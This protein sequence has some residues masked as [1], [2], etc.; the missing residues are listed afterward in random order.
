MEFVFTITVLIIAYQLTVNTSNKRQIKGLRDQV[1]K[2]TEQ[3]SE[4]N[5][6]YEMILLYGK[7]VKKIKKESKE[8]HNEKR[9]GQGS[10]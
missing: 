7:A 4:S 3:V 9:S 8:G 10:D 5:Q 2:L 1:N 6:H